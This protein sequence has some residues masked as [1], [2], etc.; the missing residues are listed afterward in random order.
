[1]TLQ[2]QQNTNEVKTLERKVI[3]RRI[4]LYQ[5]SPNKVL[6][7]LN[8]PTKNRSFIKFIYLLVNQLYN[9]NTIEFVSINKLMN[10][11][12]RQ[13]RAK[14]I[15]V[16]MIVWTPNISIGKYFVETIINRKKSISSL[17]KYFIITDD[18]ESINDNT[19]RITEINEYIVR[20]R[21]TVNE[22]YQLISKWL[23]KYINY[24]KENYKDDQELLEDY[25]NKV[26]RYLFPVIFKDQQQDQS[27]DSEDNQEEEGSIEEM[28]RIVSESQE[29]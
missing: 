20:N 3:N 23:V 6:V 4:L 10:I 7:G 29:Q 16:E 21:V 5:S 28:N 9:I 8:R 19:Y 27:Q 25:I 18:Y 11:I 2:A 17:Y 24:W 12:R 26:Y 14:I 1:M 15:T 22:L 13:N